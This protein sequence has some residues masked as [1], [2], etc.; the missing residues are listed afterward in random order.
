MSSGNNSP[1]EQEIQ[2]VAPQV[3]PEAI[4]SLRFLGFEDRVI[5]KEIIEKN[6][7]KNSKT[8]EDYDAKTGTKRGASGE[9]SS[10]EEK[11][12]P[13]HQIMKNYIVLKKKLQ[14]NNLE[15]KNYE[16]LCMDFQVNCQTY[17]I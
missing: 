17:F 15:L 6:H 12:M 8:L 13:K 4:R 9:G 11:K 14:F 10:G 5:I 1:F 16:N 7:V 2:N 3:R